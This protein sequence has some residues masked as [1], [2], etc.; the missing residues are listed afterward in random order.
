MIDERRL[1]IGGGTGAD[2]CSV[3][4]TEKLF[5][6][7]ASRNRHFQGVLPVGA[8]EV[9]GRPLFRREN[10][11]IGIDLPSYRRVTAIPLPDQKEAIGLLRFRVKRNKTGSIGNLHRTRPVMVKD[12]NRNP[13][14]SLQDFP[15]RE[16]RYDANHR[17]ISKL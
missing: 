12:Y 16:S 15:H 4:E 3:T 17:L 13:L 2:V 5:E 10:A 1:M 14:I 6:R 8:D 9:R 11:E 7:D